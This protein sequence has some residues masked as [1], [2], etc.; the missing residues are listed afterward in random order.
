[1]LDE[2]RLH[3]G[4]PAGHVGPVKGPVPGGADQ[5][6]AQAAGEV[7]GG[8]GGPAA[9]PTGA[10][11]SLQGTPAW[12]KGSEEKHNGLRVFS[13]DCGRTTRGPLRS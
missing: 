9:P 10:S 1:M 6:G 13:R 5:P 4:P 3:L 12:S 2:L 7:Q 11:E 8:D